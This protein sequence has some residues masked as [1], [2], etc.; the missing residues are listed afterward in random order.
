MTYDA[1]GV[2]MRLDGLRE[3]TAKAAAS[4]KL[5][6]R[7]SKGEKR[8]RKRMAEVAAVYDLTPAPRTVADILPDHGEREAARPAPVAAGKWLSAS[9]THDAAAVIAAGFDETARRDRH[10]TRVWVA[11]VDGNSHQIERIRAEAKA[12]DDG[13]AAG[14]REISHR[15]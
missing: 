5:S 8:N 12:P 15:S 6:T 10:H 4:Q 13:R 7:L 3:A 1:K 11:L 2:V 9:V 14:A